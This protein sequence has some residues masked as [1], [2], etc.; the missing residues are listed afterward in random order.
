MIDNVWTIIRVFVAFAFTFV[1]DIVIIVFYNCIPPK[2][3]I[4]R[5]SMQCLSHVL[6]IHGQPEFG[7]RVGF[8][9]KISIDVKTIVFQDTARM[10]GH[11]FLLVL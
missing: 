9:E 4:I 1:G 2:F 3:E 10:A 8:H 5:M 7:C 6:L 11:P